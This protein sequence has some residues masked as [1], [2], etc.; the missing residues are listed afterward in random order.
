MSAAIRSESEYLKLYDNV[1]DEIAIGD[2]SA[3]YLW[4]KDTPQLIHETIPEARIIMIL[5][6][7]TEKAFSHYLMHLRDGSE[8]NLSFYDALKLDYDR[9]TN[10]DLP[11][12]ISISDT[13]YTLSR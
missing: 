9:E 6:D 7:P 1:R 2:A 10:M 13:V 8:T 12:P 11:S 3:S 5:R 4:S